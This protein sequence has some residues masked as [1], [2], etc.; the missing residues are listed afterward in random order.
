MSHLGRDILNEK[1]HIEELIVYMG[2]VTLRGRDGL[3][4]TCHI[5]K[6]MVYM[7]NVTLRKEW[8]IWDMSH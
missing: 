4:G 8:F 3:H 6:G 7:G 5:E 2:H 1:C